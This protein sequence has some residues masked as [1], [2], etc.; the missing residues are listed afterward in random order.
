MT[1]VFSLIVLLVIFVSLF[2]LLL[3]DKDSRTKQLRQCAGQLGLEYRPFASLS[4]QVRDARFRIINLGQLHHFRHLLEGQFSQSQHPYRLNLLDY[5]LLSNDGTANQTLMLID[6]PLPTGRFRLQQK[7]WLSGDVF[8]DQY[9]DDLR[10]LLPGQLHP[11]IN[12]WQIF[13]ER[14]GEI[15]RL[16]NEE[17]RQWLLAHPHLHIE[18]SNG[19]LLLYRPQ[20]LLDENS[21]SPALSAGC[22]LA[23]QLQQSTS[24]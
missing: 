8:S 4:P 11:D 19:I 3:I 12:Q 14:P 13:S 7:Q 21:I 16:L 10:R 20:H 17:V 5:S 15:S 1:L 22:E 24:L 18:W 2:L 9:Q 6:C 23:Q